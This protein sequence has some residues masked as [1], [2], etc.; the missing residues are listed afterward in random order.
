[1]A[2]SRLTTAQRAAKVARYL[3]KKK[4]RQYLKKVQYQSRKRVADVRP[5][6]KGRFVSEDKAGA[7]FEEYWREMCERHKTERHF[8]I[9]K[10]DR[11]SSKVKSVKFPNESKMEK[12][13]KKVIDP[14]QLHPE[15]QLQISSEL[16]WKQPQP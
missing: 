12:N 1:M 15:F 11:E 8:A 16:G 3:E 7:L 6:F 4:R 14:L 5:R 10:V 2:S 13:I 9:V